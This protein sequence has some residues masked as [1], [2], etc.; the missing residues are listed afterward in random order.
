MQVA[1]TLFFSLSCIAVP[2]LVGDEAFG[3]VILT[4]ASTAG[5]WMNLLLP[6]VI[7]IYSRAP[8]GRERHLW[9][10][11]VAWILLL[12]VLCLIDGII[13]MLEPQSST[14]NEPK[15]SSECQQAF[16]RHRATSDVELFA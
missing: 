13:K 16:Q 8:V 9:L 14:P 12:G 10:M 15:L 7:L 3:N 11:K 6:A 1:L 2:T 5:V 4:V